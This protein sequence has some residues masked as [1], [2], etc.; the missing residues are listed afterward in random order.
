LERG[1]AITYLY[2]A[3]CQNCKTAVEKV[4]AACKEYKD[5]EGPGKSKKGLIAASVPYL[6]LIAVASVGIVAGMALKGEPRQQTGRGG[7]A[8][9]GFD[10]KA[11]DEAVG[12]EG[13]RLRAEYEPKLAQ[14][15]AQIKDLS[16]NLEDANAR[17]K[18]DYDA[19]LD[20]KQKLDK[21]GGENLLA[22][23]RKLEGDNEKNKSKI[24]EILARN[25][26]LVGERD[27]LSQEKM[28]LTREA[29]KST[30]LAAQLDLSDIQI[31]VSAWESAYNNA[32]HEALLSCYAENSEYK[33]DYRAN[34]KETVATFNKGV[35]K[36]RY[37]VSANVKD[38][39]VKENEI[40]LPVKMVVRDAESNSVVT[41]VTQKWTLVKEGGRWRISKQEE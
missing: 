5:F 32:D 20:L 25:E 1:K 14:N 18:N 11:V 38:A 9:A 13:E 29:R 31:V 35:G 40:S 21:V 12:K 34:R 4:I 10:R 16:K 39:N 37:R 41:D 17:S 3:Y 23:I 26:A 27:R 24:E 2:L 19:I 6:V 7:T 28:E 36:Y 30:E 8:A 33:K 15:S 22:Q